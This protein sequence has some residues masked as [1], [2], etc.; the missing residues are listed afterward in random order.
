MFPTAPS[1]GKRGPALP[2]CGSAARREGQEGPVTGAPG[3]RDVGRGT[4]A[5]RP[6]GDTWWPP[7]KASVRVRFDHAAWAWTAVYAA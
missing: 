5:R 1:L 6:P 4:Q 7:V 3:G 2:Q